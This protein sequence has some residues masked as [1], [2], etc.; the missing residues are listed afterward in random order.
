MPQLIERLKEEGRSELDLARSWPETDTERLA[1][2]LGV[3]VIFRVARTDGGLSPD[4][5]IVMAASGGVRLSSDPDEVVEYVELSL[6]RHPYARKVERLQSV[7]TGEAHLIAIVG[8]RTM[9]EAFGIHWASLQGYPTL[10]TRSFALPAGISDF[11]LV[12]IFTGWSLWW[13]QLGWSQSS[14]QVDWWR[15]QSHLSSVRLKLGVDPAG[16]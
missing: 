5:A 14:G 12:N 15:Q 9:A 1:H 6:G 11:W 3:E 8:T 2:K 13:S 16:G 10:P 7:A 4:R